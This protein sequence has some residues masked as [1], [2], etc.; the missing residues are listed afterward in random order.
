MR[1]RRLEDILEECLSACLEGRRSIEESLSLYPGFAEELEPLLRTAA[2]VARETY[3]WGPPEELQE[4]AHGRFLTAAQRR[5]GKLVVRPALWRW[6][7]A[8][9]AGG[10]VVVA[11]TLVSMALL[12]DSGSQP[13][14]GVRVE[15]LTPAPTPAGT[16]AVAVLTPHLEKV[17]TKLAELRTTVEQGGPVQNVITELKAAT[18]EI[19]MQ[20]KTASAVDEAEKKELVSV[21]SEQ[22]V[23]LSSLV[24]G[25]AVNGEFEEVKSTLGLTEEIARQLGLTLPELTA[26]PTPAPTPI[27]TP[28]PTP[29]PAPTPEPTPTPTR[30]PEPTPTP[31]PTPESTPTPKPPGPILH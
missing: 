30:T 2:E 14:A 19:A 8:A 7:L 22:Y 10:V 18:S 11:L 23:L 5:E 16:G 6:G 26:T 25:P 28:E 13:P 27:P 9:A 4:K 17:H 24:E 15:L 29:T 1:R 3:Y 31:A 21:I 20:L 12:R